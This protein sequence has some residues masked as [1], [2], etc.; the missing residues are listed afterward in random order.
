MKIAACLPAYNEEANIG[1]LLQKLTLEKALDEIVV[2]ASGC[3]DRTE[4]IVRSFAPKVTLLSQ[5]ERK[6]KASAIN[7]FLELTDADIIVM[8]STDTLP[9][10][11]CIS[12]IV[13]AFKD[14]DVGMVGSRPVTTND[15]RTHMGRVSRILWEGHHHLAMTHPKMGELV[16]WRNVFDSIPSF[17]SVDEAAIEAKIIEQGYR[18]EYEPRA[19]TYNR[20]PETIA[21]L[22]VQ[23]TRIFL[24]HLNLKESG[25]TVST[26]NPV[27]TLAAVWKATPKNL[28]GFRA[29][30]TLCWVELTSRRAATKAFKAK[31]AEA[32]VW[33]TA[34]STKTL[35]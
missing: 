32:T 6:G 14:P 27:R 18:L 15:L 31:E 3:T 20:G 8:E 11:N 1:R 4:E 17:S 16:A 9:G 24:G 34:Q 7:M 29:L 23:R 33:Q 13:D 19:V 22:R 2:I 12:Y 28:K 35:R 10:G 26:M 21:D 25:Y 30:M 5:P